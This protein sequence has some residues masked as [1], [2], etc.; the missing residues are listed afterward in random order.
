MGHRAPQ[1]PLSRGLSQREATATERRF[2]LA[3]SLSQTTATFPGRRA[4]RSHLVTHPCYAFCTRSASAARPHGAHCLRSKGERGWIPPPPSCGGSS[5]RWVCWEMQTLWSLTA[6]P[7][8]ASSCAQRQQ[9]SPCANT[10]RCF[11]PKAEPLPQPRQRCVR[12]AAAAQGC[13]VRARLC[14]AA[15]RRRFAQ[16]VEGEGENSLDV[17]CTGGSVRYCLVATAPP[18]QSRHHRSYEPAFI[19]R[20]FQRDRASQDNANAAVLRWLTRNRSALL[21]SPPSPGTALHMDVA[22]AAQES[23]GS[24]PGFRL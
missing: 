4:V 9:R 3:G 8:C 20:Y 10:G 14:S 18:E 2:Q 11:L 5:R 1:P 22:G 23:S 24:V 15:Q 13:A 17:T 21:R 6:S 16:S 12:M 19:N 7:S